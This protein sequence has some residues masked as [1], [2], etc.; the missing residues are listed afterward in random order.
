MNT[1]TPLITP[2]AAPPIPKKDTAAATI[3]GLLAATATGA[4]V[5]KLG[6]SFHSQITQNL[7][8]A[9]WH[10]TAGFKSLLS[11]IGGGYDG[12]AGE[13]ISALNEAGWS[14]YWR[15]GGMWG[16]AITAGLFTFSAL[17]KKIDPIR[18]G[19][20]R[21]LLDIKALRTQSKMEDPAAII[22]G[23]MLSHAQ[24]SKGITAIG[25]SG[26]GKTQLIHRL[27]PQLKASGWR[28]ILIDGAKGDYSSA[29]EYSDCII[30]APWHDGPAWDIGKDCTTR[31]AAI[32]L[33]ARII[34]AGDKDPMWSNAARMIFT[35]A[36]CYLISSKG[37]NWGWADLWAEMTQ[38]L[39]I[40]KERATEFYPP[41]IV[42]LA[43]V[44]SKTT[45]S[46]LIN[47]MAFAS[48]IY[49]L[50]LAWGDSKE[51]VSI[52]EWLLDETDRR[53][54]IL[55][56]NG[57]F[58]QTAK[59]Y[60]QGIFGL[61]ASAV[62][63]PRMRESKTRLTIFMIDE[64]AQLG[65]IEGAEKF[66]EVGRSKTTTVLI[67]TQSPSQLREIYGDN[68]LAT[69]FATVGIRFWLR[70]T[71]NEDQQYVANQI[72]KREIW[73]PN[74]SVNTSAGGF[75][76]GNSYS[77]DEQFIMHP[78]ELGDLGPKT[79]GI[80]AIFDDGGSGLAKVFFPFTKINDQFKDVYTPNKHWNSLAVSANLVGS[81]IERSKETELLATETLDFSTV[82]LPEIE[83]YVL[84]KNEE[85]ESKEN[86][87]I[88]ELLGSQSVENLANNVGG[89][90]IGHGV[91]LALE[92]LEVMEIQVNSDINQVAIIKNVSK[93]RARMSQKEREN[94]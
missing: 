10:V 29:E 72:G 84:P 62:I 74:Q 57:E 51:K 55:Q 70:T 69:I 2:T 87:E 59:A 6:W 42:L 16:S 77:K 14:A 36:V 39:E 3:A 17:N 27:W 47:L 23:V 5:A 43:D 26:G 86:D 4:I 67:A 75:A 22:D 83:M 81:G 25:S 35:V 68:L 64:A 66:L 46:V 9:G 48:S 50:A 37:S 76:V 61:C 49:E 52:L 15:V 40:T 54:F 24:I 79:A 94:A 91:G 44:E 73:V 93:K 1:A 11:V 30:I 89:E 28:G 88:G 38:E 18:H 33:A 60:I 58:A 82:I 31:A 90:L 92:V 63:S 78:G 85:I 71:G 80:D 21:Q 41:A 12:F 7:G 13:Y 45:Q 8:S 19:R 32:E 34:P 53:S 65:R 56:A 20:G